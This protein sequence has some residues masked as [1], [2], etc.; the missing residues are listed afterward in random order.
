[1]SRTTKVQFVCV[2]AEHHRRT[3]RSRVVC[4]HLGCPSYCPAG[5]V[6]GHDWMPTLTDLA[7]LGCLGY[8]TRYEDELGAAADELAEERTPIAR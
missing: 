4:E 6:G 7:T 5:D 1:M 8:E 3:S 2:R